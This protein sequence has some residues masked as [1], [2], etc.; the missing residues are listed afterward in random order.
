MVDLGGRLKSIITYAIGTILIGA[1]LEP[2]YNAMNSI[3]VLAGVNLGFVMCLVI[4][5][6]WIIYGLELFL[7]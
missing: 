1:F 5:V 6:G 2:L 3:N 4:I 7:P